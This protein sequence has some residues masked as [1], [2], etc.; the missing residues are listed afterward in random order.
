LMMKKIEHHFLHTNII[1]LCFLKK[2]IIS[3]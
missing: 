1:I 2:T 3:I